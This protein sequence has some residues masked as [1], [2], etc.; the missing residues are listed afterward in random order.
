[1]KKI[2]SLKIAENPESIKALWAQ[3]LSHRNLLLQNTDWTQIPNSG[4]SEECVLQYKVWRQQLRNI[5]ANSSIPINMVVNTT[6][7]LA[8][9]MPKL[10]WAKESKN[11][12]QFLK[13]SN[14]KSAAI[15]VNALLSEF[16]IDYQLLQIDIKFM[17]DYDA[18]FKTLED[19]SDIV[20]DSDPKA[21]AEKLNTKEKTY[22]NIL[23]QIKLERD[24]YYT[25]IDSQQETGVLYTMHHKFLEDIDGYRHRL[26]E[27]FSP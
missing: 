4:L 27:T 5:K 11:E 2:K 16:V 7:V 25:S 20:S 6:K 22:K 18:G 10:E 19:I 23:K 24:K 26:L 13:D 8:A 17:L 15:L 12:L 14:K 3:A 9:H 21:V 1:M